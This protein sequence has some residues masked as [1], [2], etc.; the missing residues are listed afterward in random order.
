MLRSLAAIDATGM[1]R[2]H[3]WA[4]QDVADRLDHAIIFRAVGTQST[5]LLEEGYAAKGFRIDTKSCDWG[6]MRGF[7]CVDPRFSKV[8]GDAVKVATNATFTAEALRGDIRHDAVGGMPVANQRVPGWRAGCKPVVIS[9]GRYAE[10]TRDGLAGTADRDGIIRG[11]SKNNGRDRSA[12]VELAWALIP[13]RHCRLVRSY[14]AAVGAM[15]DGAY[16]VFIDAGGRLTQQRPGDPGAL[17]VLGND[18]V[19]GLTNPDS[20]EYGY[21]ACVTGDYDLFGAW[22]PAD[23]RHDRYVAGHGANV[24]VRAVD[25]YRQQNPNDT[26]AHFQQHYRLGNIS[27][28]LNMIKVNLNTALISKGAYPGGNLVHHSDEIGNPSP[29]LRKS[30]D[31]SFPLLAFVPRGRCSPATGADTPVCALNTNDFRTLVTN[32]RAA[33]IAPE[34][35]PEWASFATG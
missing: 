2:R 20:D 8:A 6:P 4:I 28:R 21:K 7:V 34:L 13:A 22:A 1:P 23:R 27:P 12:G 11:T 35:R 17:S 25:E 14:A 18:A 15:P 3:A 33:G 32:C 26:N 29:G 5:G 19:L 30:L 10:L 9:A 24:D 16:G 31:E